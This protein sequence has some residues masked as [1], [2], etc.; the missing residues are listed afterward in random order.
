MLQTLKTASIDPPIVDLITRLAGLTYC[1]P[2]QSC[3]GHFLVPGQTDTR[4]C[5]PLPL[6]DVGSP[7]V[8][9]IAYVAIC[10][11]NNAPGK[12][13]LGKLAN[14]PAADPCYVQFGSAEWFWKR[15]INSFVLQVE[16]ARFAARDKVSISFEEARLLERVRD[17]F[18]QVLR[19]MI[20]EDLHG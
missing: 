16:P 6:S 10:I 14:I 3:Y 12:R 5:E 17:R 4:N 11:E 7:V 18:F 2:L 1:F 9:R 19:K 20:Q 8:Y 13:L 15:Q